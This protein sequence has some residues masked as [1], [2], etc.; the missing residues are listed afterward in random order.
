MEKMVLIFVLAGCLLI[1]ISRAETG[2]SLYSM[3]A[4][5]FLQ[6]ERVRQPIDLA[7][8]DHM[9]LSA[10]IFHETNQRR[11]NHDLAPL[12]HLP[13]LQEAAELHARS[14]AEEGYLSH[15]NQDSSKR[16]TPWDSVRLAGLKPSFVSENVADHFGIQYEPGTRVYP[17]EKNGRVQFSRT[18]GGPPIP[19]HTYRSFAESL[20]DQWMGSPLHRENILSGQARY[21]GAACAKR[22]PESRMAMEKFYCVQVFAAL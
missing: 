4:D 21:L 5:T 7:R 12:D 19:N 22:E 15:T 13:E 1:P 11:K 20:L 6:M 10:A 2:D 16:R 14:M 17:S 8:I 9:M 3:P 18:P